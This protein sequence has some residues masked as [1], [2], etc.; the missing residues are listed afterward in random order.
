MHRM[1]FEMRDLQKK[2]PLTSLTRAVIYCIQISK[3][4]PLT[5]LALDFV[6]NL[7][8]SAVMFS[9]NKPLI[10]GANLVCQHDEKTKSSN[11]KSC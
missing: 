2:F 6:T 3:S 8:G 4:L 5:K 11:G 7:H 9:K 10:S 1:Y